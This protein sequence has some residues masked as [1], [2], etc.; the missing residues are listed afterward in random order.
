[1]NSIK[2]QFNNLNKTRGVFFKTQIIPFIQHYRRERCHCSK[3]LT[4]A[5]VIAMKG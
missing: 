2:K 5:V 1:M 4:K 3:L